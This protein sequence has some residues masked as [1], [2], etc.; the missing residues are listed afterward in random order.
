MSIITL[1]Q[2]QADF[3]AEMEDCYDL[4][5]MEERIDYDPVDLD[6]YEYQQGLYL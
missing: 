5:S 6:D 2:L 1:Q 3:F 4:E